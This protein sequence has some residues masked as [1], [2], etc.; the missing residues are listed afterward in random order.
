MARPRKTNPD[1]L[2]REVLRVRWRARKK[3]ALAEL[4]LAAGRTRVW[5]NGPDGK[6]REKWI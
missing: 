6:I 3:K 2:D 5:V 1:K 4:R